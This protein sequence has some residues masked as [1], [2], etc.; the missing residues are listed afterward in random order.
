MH[1]RGNVDLT[2]SLCNFTRNMVLSEGGAIRVFNVQQ[3]GQRA[4][5][6]M[7]DNNIVGNEAGARKAGETEQASPAGGGI[8]F[9]G[10]GVDLDLRD[11]IFAR[12]RA[13]QGG[14]LSIRPVGDCNI[15]GNNT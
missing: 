3:G 5:F 4:R 11:N 7:A 2:L 14:A 10:N 9:E 6:V 12:N 13:S 1:T 15:V 8:A